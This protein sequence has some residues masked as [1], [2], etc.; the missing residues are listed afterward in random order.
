MGTQQPARPVRGR[1]RVGA[2]GAANWPAL[3]NRQHGVVTRR[4]LLAPASAIRT[5]K[6]RVEAG[7]LHH[8]HRGVYALGHGASEQARPLAGRRSRL[9]PGRAAEPPQRGSTMGAYARPPGCRRSHLRA[10]RECGDRGI[11]STGW[12]RRNRIGRSSTRSRSPPSPAPSS[13]SPR[14]STSRRC[15][16]LSRRPIGSTCSRCQPSR[17]SARGVMVAAACARS[18][19]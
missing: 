2:A 1:G 19:R 11:S 6:R 5:I 9:W 10:G 17:S 7:R 15:D 16:A 3:A 4:Q 12:D 18:A 8:L 13:I 14:S